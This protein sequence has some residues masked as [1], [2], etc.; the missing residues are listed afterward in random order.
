MCYGAEATRRWKHR[1]LERDF[2]KLGCLRVGVTTSPPDP[3]A[4]EISH[5]GF[6]KIRQIKLAIRFSENHRAKSAIFPF[7]PLPKLALRPGTILTWHHNCFGL[8]I[9]EMCKWLVCANAQIVCLVSWR[10]C[11]H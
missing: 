2:E 7:L 6:C 10:I 9:S 8:S 4:P 3:P 11:A 5:F 1:D